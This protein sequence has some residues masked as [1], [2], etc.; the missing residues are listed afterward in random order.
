MSCPA[1][2]DYCLDYADVVWGDKS[3]ATLMGKIQ[4]LQ[5]KAAKLI[6]DRSKHSSATEALT[7]LGWDTMATR[8]RFHR[9]FLVYK[10][11]NG[12][13]DW[14]FTF[15]HFKNIHCYNTRFNNN[16]CKPQSCHSWGQ[17]R[18]I[19]HAIDD[20]N[21]LPKDIKNISDFLTFKHRIRNI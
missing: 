10:S 1:L 2:Q 15:N 21:I 7:Q 13:I 17:H 9:L 12:L 16:I 18:F 4:V 8:R 11:L 20:W 6:L 19:S 14:N 5:N 3:N